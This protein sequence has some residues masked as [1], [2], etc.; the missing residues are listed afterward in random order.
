MSKIWMVHDV[1]KTYIEAVTK[2]GERRVLD[3]EGNVNMWPR[4]GQNTWLRGSGN[5]W[6]IKNRTQSCFVLYKVLGFDALSLVSALPRKRDSVSLYVNF[7][8][9]T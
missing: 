6:L 5:T 7:M 2:W 8:S 4:G 9:R 3:T 1:H